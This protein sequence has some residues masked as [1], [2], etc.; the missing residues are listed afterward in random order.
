MDFIHFEFE[1]TL[2]EDF[3]HFEFELSLQV[4]PSC[5]LVFTTVRIFSVASKIK[6]PEGF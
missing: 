1:L 2:L 3:S 4:R 6:E 5:P